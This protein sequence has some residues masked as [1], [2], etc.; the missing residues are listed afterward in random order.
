MG[1]WR[2][3]KR[4]GLR[5]QRTQSFWSWWGGRRG[6]VAERGFTFFGSKI[7]EKRICDVVDPKYS[8]I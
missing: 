3:G 7:A 4:M 8:S 2:V 5:A 6:D 1:L